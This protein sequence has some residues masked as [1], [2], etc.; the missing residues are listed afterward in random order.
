MK[1]RIVE[2]G[3]L[4]GRFFIQKKVLGLFWVYYE[5]PIFTERSNGNLYYRGCEKV[6]YDSLCA[7]SC[8]IYAIGDTRD[9]GWFY[10][11][12]RTV[13][14]WN[15][16]KNKRVFV[17]IS[18]LFGLGEPFLRSFS[19]FS[20]HWEQLKTLYDANLDERKKKKL[21]KKITWVSNVYNV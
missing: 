17:K 10:H 12:N 16:D 8:T 7:A 4:S 11:G 9:E 13:V 19:V 15:S 3:S 1:F 20:Y 6:E 18:M 5:E 21:A 14:G 2:R